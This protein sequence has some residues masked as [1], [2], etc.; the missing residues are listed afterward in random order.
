MCQE[1]TSTQTN[2]FADVRMDERDNDWLGE[3]SRQ[4]R[5]RDGGGGGDK[6]RKKIKGRTLFYGLKV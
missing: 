2:L 6:I 3:L 1:V 5:E 4:T